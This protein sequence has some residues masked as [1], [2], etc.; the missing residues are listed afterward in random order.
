MGSGK[1]NNIRVSY[2]FNR[3]F[4]AHVDA[5]RGVS[6]GHFMAMGPGL[7]LL[8]NLFPSFKCSVVSHRGKL[9]I[10]FDVDSG[11]GNIVLIGRAQENGKELKHHVFEDSIY[12]ELKPEADL[13]VVVTGI[14]G[15]GREQLQ[16]CPIWE[17]NKTI[18]SPKSLARM[19]YDELLKNYSRP[20][21]RMPS[22][23]IILHSIPWVWFSFDN[24]RFIHY[25]YG[26]S[27]VPSVSCF[28]RHIRKRCTAGDIWRKSSN[29]VI[30]MGAANDNKKPDHEHPY[31]FSSVA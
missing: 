10:P 17:R 28:S 13:E 19:S 11:R 15:E 20:N 16:V 27:M 2:K 12:K 21:T 31:G 25:V 24:W 6:L 14:I 1:D 26:N 30:Y 9:Y 29:K 5:F 23:R 3:Y 18:H 7:I 22:P 8:V 4:L